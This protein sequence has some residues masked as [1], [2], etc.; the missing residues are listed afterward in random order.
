[1]KTIVK[2][3][4]KGISSLSVLNCHYCSFLEKVTCDFLVDGNQWFFCIPFQPDSVSKDSRSPCYLL[5]ETNKKFKVRAVSL[6]L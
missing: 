3:K 4:T 5:L 2:L 1:M 6:F